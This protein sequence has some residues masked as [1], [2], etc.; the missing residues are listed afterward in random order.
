M[1][2]AVRTILV[3]ALAVGLMAVFLRNADFGQV[4]AA[5]RAARVDL[6]AFAVVLTGVTYVIRAE[7]WQYML[8]PLGPTRFGVALRTTVI[9]FAA[10]AVLPAR[11]GEVLRP[12]LLARREGLSTT[13]VFATI[14]VERMLDLVAVLGLLAVYLLVLDEGVRRRSPLLYGAVETGGL[15]MA[16]VAVAGLAVM[17][18]LAGHPERLHGW[19][20]R[21]ERV[22]PGRL[23]A[24]VAH[25]ARML[26][27]GFAVLRQPRRLVATLAWSLALWVT[28]CVEIWVVAVAFGLALPF[29]GTFLLSAMLVVGIAIPTPG[30][31]G[32]FHEAFRLGAT[33]FYGAANDV[34]VGAALVL[35]AAAM[36]PVVAVGLVWVMQDGL[37][38]GGLQQLA[39]RARAEEEAK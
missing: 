1:R 2:A 3:T 39:R 36:A 37:R 6:L 24:R 20:L 28:I 19:M 17:Y 22:L 8:G 16:G 23:A 9:G 12:Y 10:S 25:L 31:V 5:V 34:A 4:W 26:V 15:V 11:V 18:V 29:A 27:Q 38:L 32:G 35:H 21:A 30:G 14:I 7:R 33:S 13:S